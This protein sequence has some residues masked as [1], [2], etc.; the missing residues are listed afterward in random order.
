MLRNIET[1]LDRGVNT[2]ATSTATVV[3]SP[4]R[5]YLMRSEWDWS[6]LRDYVV[7][8][9]ESRFGPFPRETHKEIGIFKGFMKRW[10]PDAEVIARYAFEVE[11]GRWA[12]APISVYRFCQNSDPYFAEVILERVRAAA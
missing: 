8:E 12:G 2:V 5:G 3:S 11:N 1:D 9:I 6:D 7:H 4:S 10:G